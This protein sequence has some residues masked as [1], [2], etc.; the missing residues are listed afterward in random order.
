L[1]PL[2]DKQIYVIGPQKAQNE[3]MASYLEQETGSRCVVVKDFRG[4]QVANDSDGRSRGL[5]LWDCFGREKEACLSILDTDAESVAAQHYVALFNLT[6]SSGV[7]GEAVALGVRGFFYLNESLKKFKHGVYAI[8]NGEVWAPR[9]IMSEFI[10][11]RK[12]G[13]RSQGRYDYFLT[14]REIE[15][16]QKVAGGYSNSRIAEDLCISPHTVKTHLYNA[17]KKIKAP[18]RLQAAL[19]AV[20]NL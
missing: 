3:L 10:I 18:G 15:I 13:K 17:Y 4:V 8:F 1:P 11:E 2:K 14:T 9:K 20:K 19:W 16:L 12:Q 7:E 5:A 6:P